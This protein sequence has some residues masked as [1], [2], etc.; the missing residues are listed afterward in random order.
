MVASYLRK[1]TATTRP[2]VSGEGS[3]HIIGSFLPFLVAVGTFFHIV[4]IAKSKKYD[5][6]HVQGRFV[7]PISIDRY[8]KS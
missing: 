1:H 6:D 7:I 8:M 5:E 2:D 3:D 4:F